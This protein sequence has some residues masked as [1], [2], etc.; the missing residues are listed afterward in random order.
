MKNTIFGGFFPVKL[1][2]LQLEACVLKLFAM[3]EDRGSLQH[4]K[5]FM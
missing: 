5:E 2:N 1:R 4:G 3:W